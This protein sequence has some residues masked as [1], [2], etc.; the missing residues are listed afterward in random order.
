MIG[1]DKSEL[2]HIH[3]KMGDFI[4]NN[5]EEIAAEIKETQNEHTGKRREN[6]L[7]YIIISSLLQIGITVY[8]AS[9]TFLV[10]AVI[11]GIIMIISNDAGI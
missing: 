8:F 5:C 7:P 4:A 6:L 11:M 1:S 10:I 9:N 2:E 3:N